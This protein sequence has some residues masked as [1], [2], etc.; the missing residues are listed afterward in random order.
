MRKLALAGLLAFL[1]AVVFAPAAVAQ[2]QNDQMN[3]DMMGS[4]SASAMGDESLGAAII[5]QPWA[6]GTSSSISESIN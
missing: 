5:R 3:D 2:M 4:T 6:S 1:V